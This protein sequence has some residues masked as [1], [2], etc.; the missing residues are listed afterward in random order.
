M[1]SP[2]I[3]NCCGPAAALDKKRRRSFPQYLHKRRKEQTV[4][5]MHGM[6]EEGRTAKI[7]QKFWVYLFIT[8]ALL[9]ILCVFPLACGGG[10][11]DVSDEPPSNTVELIQL[12]TGHTSL[13]Q[14]SQDKVV[15]LVQS[16]LSR[17]QIFYE[18]DKKPYMDFFNAYPSLKGCENFN[19]LS[20]WCGNNIHLCFDKDTSDSQNPFISTEFRLYLDGNCD[21]VEYRYLLRVDYKPSEPPVITKRSAWIA[22][23]LKNFE[24]LGFQVAIYIDADENGNFTQ[25][26]G[27]YEG[28]GEDQL[29]TANVTGSVNSP[30]VTWVP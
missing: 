4:E 29:K 19:E 23:Y 22:I 14:D 11:E 10:D 5:E 16:S 30:E 2:E 9:L 21:N 7:Y 8:G 13:D 1:V 3:R 20:E 18:M 24:G 12:S 26:S 28:E 15:T 27:V 6:V 25:Y 17:W